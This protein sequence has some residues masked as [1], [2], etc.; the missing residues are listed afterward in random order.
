MPLF[1]R[2]AAFT[3]AVLLAE[4]YLSLP[5]RAQ[6][7]SPQTSL[8]QVALPGKLV[9]IEKP[10]I[11]TKPKAKSA[12]E[13]ALYDAALALGMVRWNNG[14][15]KLLINVIDVIEFTGAGLWNGEKVARAT[16]GYDFVLPATRMDVEKMAA[17]NKPMRDISV[18][19]KGLSWDEET[20]G[21]FKKPGATSADA[22]LQPM[23]LLPWAVV[24]S[25]SQA[26]D[27]LKLENVD[28]QRELS[29]TTPAG[30]NFKARLDKA[31][32]PIRTQMQIGDQLW[33]GEFSDFVIDGEDYN[34]YFPRRLQI[35]AQGQLVTDLTIGR[36]PADKKLDL[37]EGNNIFPNPY[38]VF[39]VPKEMAQR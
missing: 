27:K 19:A 29:V 10:D 38:V 6:T 20:P 31:G 1:K 30:H 24:L 37:P 28:G 15:K 33:T 5:A 21:L 8:T 16:I 17:D 25:G 36:L 3:V 2:C 35:K 12:A 18:A 34:F 7:P 39:P 23:W 4:F 14:Q 26:L 22:R 13:D 11:R 9:D 32:F